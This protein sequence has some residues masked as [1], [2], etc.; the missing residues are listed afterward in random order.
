L[1]LA[2]SLLL[3]ACDSPSVL[4]SR[5]Q[6]RFE[7]L[8]QQLI[9]WIPDP[10]NAVLARVDGHN[11]RAS[12]FKIALEDLSVNERKRFES[13]QG[14]KRWLEAL[15]RQTI[16]M[17][18]GENA[19]LDQGEEFQHKLK[20]FR[21]SLL[22]SELRKRARIESPISDAE[23][24]RFYEKHIRDFS[25]IEIEASHI[26]LKELTEAKRA[27]ALLKRGKP[28]ATLARAMSLDRATAKKGGKMGL[29]KQGQ[30]NLQLETAL[31]AIEK[32]QITP[33]L[34]SASG[35]EI[36][37]KDGESVVPQS[38]DAVKEQVRE[39]L[40]SERFGQWV[41]RLRA[42]KKIEI[43]DKTL[44]AL[45]LSFSGDSSSGPITNSN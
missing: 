11:I 8:R 14:R 30:M 9:S 20:R 5:A 2:S 40:E 37:K 36:V 43:D 29:L 42:A 38:F 17:T 44:Q 22:I 21:K 33:I 32:G 16:Q 4:I 18:A 35:Y 39:Q 25:Q 1:L 24:R 27:E 34:K 26:V 13:P 28:F 7:N 12:D 41:N 23:A 15:I 31:L 45:D 10:R 19:G 6:N 3:A